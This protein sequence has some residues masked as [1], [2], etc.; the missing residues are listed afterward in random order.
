MQYKQKKPNKTKNTVIT[1][2]P[3]Q[4]MRFFERKV[5]YLVA[6]LALHVQEAGLRSLNKPLT[7]VCVLLL[8][9]GGVQQVGVKETHF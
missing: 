9:Q 6:R 3:L 2:V 4:T 8:L 7:L 5:S 1:E